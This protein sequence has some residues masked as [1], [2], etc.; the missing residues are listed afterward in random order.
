MGAGGNVHADVLAGREAEID[1]EDVYQGQEMRDEV[2]FH[3]EMEGRFG[4]GW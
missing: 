3:G 4:M 1:W 2:P